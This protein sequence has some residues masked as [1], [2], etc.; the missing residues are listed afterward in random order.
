[1]DKLFNSFSSLPKWL[2]ILFAVVLIGGIGYMMYSAVFGSD[3]DNSNDNS[4]NIDKRSSVIIGMSDASDV[5][6][7]ASS[8]LQAYEQGKHQSANDFWDSLDGVKP[9]TKEGEDNSNDGGLNIGSGRSVPDGNGNAYLDPN[10]YSEMEM[11][12]IRSGFKTKADIDRDHAESRA[13]RKAL[14]DIRNQTKC[15]TTES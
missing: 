13:T 15:R 3:K 4:K 11:Y 1:M 9:E 5:V 8:R 7:K 10:E 2:L 14:E 12:L 6:D